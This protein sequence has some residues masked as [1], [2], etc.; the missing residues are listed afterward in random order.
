MG[1]QGY[2]VL[3]RDQK[4]RRTRTGVGDAAVSSGARMEVCFRGG[5]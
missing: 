3:E 4:L 1:N 5:G 2:R